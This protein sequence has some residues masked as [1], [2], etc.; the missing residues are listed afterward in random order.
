MDRVM[1]YA[2]FKQ[3]VIPQ[4]PAEIAITG[5]ERNGFC[6]HFLETANIRRGGG[7]M[8]VGVGSDVEKEPRPSLTPEADNTD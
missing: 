6:D 5:V 2:I 8:A 7:G 1:I 3:V 4:S